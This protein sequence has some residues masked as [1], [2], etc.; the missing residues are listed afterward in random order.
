[1]HCF[2]TSQT[3]EDSS[4][5]SDRNLFPV[6]SSAYHSVLLSQNSG[7]NI[8][9]EAIGSA[10][11]IAQQISGNGHCHTKGVSD[12]ASAP[13]LPISKWFHYSVP[14]NQPGEDTR[15]NFISCPHI[16]MD[17]FER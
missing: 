8:D 3:R 14:E 1:M 13:D 5:V 4:T 7:S 17:S 15:Y 11:L 10:I 6:V 2:L 16:I 12:L 9:R